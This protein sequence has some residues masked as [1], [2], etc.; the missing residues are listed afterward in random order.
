MTD[1]TVYAG[2][3]SSAV[4]ATWCLRNQRYANECIVSPGPAR[5]FALATMKSHA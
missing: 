2:A 5:L 4:V 3:K 1:V